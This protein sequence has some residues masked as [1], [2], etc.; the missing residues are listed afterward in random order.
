[1][2]FLSAYL[3]P[4]RIAALLRASVILVLGVVA[5]RII[6]GWF[7]Q[8]LARKGRPQ[9]SI[10]AR[11]IVFYSLLALVSTMVLH[12]LGF[13]LGVLFGAAGILTVAIGF[14]SQ[15]SASNLVSG[16][17]LIAERSFVVGDTIQVGEHTGEILS[18]DLLSVKL[19][20]L[21][22]ILVRVPNEEIIKSRVKNITHFPIRRCD[23]PVQVAIDSD[24]S[25]ARRALSAV[26]ARNPQCLVDPGP[27]FHVVRFTDNGI[28]LL[29][30]V[31]ARREGF[32]GFQTKVRED[33]RDAF[34]KE[35]IPTVVPQM[36]MRYEEKR[37]E[38]AAPSA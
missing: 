23:V 17:F 28:G 34:L 15:T 37:D 5:A 18:I 38:R 16:I 4:E 31:W 8:A 35:G 7:G 32:A 12:E 3:T 30:S 21:D 13:H 11:R 20:T 19:R 24:L 26:A 22:N 29:L 2:S 9:E 25:K 6:A 1:M 27:E 14:A 36:V 10:L 33:L